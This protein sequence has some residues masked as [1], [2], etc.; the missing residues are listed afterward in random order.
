MQEALVLFD[1][2]CNS[3]WFVR[4]SI[5]LF[6]NKV[7]DATPFYYTA[8]LTRFAVTSSQVDLFKEKLPRSPIAN[9]FPDYHGGSDLQAACDYFTSRFVGLNQNPS[10]QV[11]VRTLLIARIE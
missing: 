3:R 11:Y 8:L 1:S 7:R 5:I 4:T 9:Y 2:I 6:L 10:K